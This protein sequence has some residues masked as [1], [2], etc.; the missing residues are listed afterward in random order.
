MKR[1][2]AV[3]AAVVA[4]VPMAPPAAARQSQED[5]ARLEAVEI[6][7]DAVVLDDHRRPVT[8]LT[9]ADFQV[10]EDGKE[11]EIADFTAV[12][13]A[14]RGEAEAAST[15]LPTFR[16]FVLTDGTVQD[17]HFADVVDAVEQFVRERMT[18]SD[19]V[20]L[21][22]IGTGGLAL[23][24]PTTNDREA[25]LKVLAKVT[26]GGTGAIAESIRESARA[27]EQQIPALEAAV[28]GLGA[29][30]AGPGPAVV[31]SRTPG[32]LQ[33]EL[34]FLRTALSRA[35]EI[36]AMRQSTNFYDSLAALIDAH[37]VVPGRRNITMFS[38]GFQTASNTTAFRDTT[39]NAAAAAG[40]ALYVI[41]ARGLAGEVDRGSATRADI[42]RRQSI[43][44]MRGAD[45]N[46][47]RTSS[48]GGGSIFD[49]LKSSPTAVSR[50]DV[51]EDLASGTGGLFLK[52]SNDLAEGLAEIDRDLRNYYVLRYTPRE[53]Q[54]RGEFRRIEVRLRKPGLDV[55]AREGYFAVPA[56]AEGLFRLEDQRLMIRAAQAKPGGGLQFAARPFVSRGAR[57]GTRVSYAIVVAPDAVRL[58]KQEKGAREAR[59]FGLVIA[60]DASGR[61]LATQRLPWTVEVRPEDEERFRDGGLR[62][63]GGLEVTAGE[64]AEVEFVLSDEAANRAGRV[65]AKVRPADWVRG[66]AL[67]DLIIGGVVAKAG[68]R[69]EPAFRSGDL[70]VVPSVVPALARS[71]SLNVVAAAYWPEGRAIQKPVLSIWRG[72]EMVGSVELEI[73]KGENGAGGTVFASVPLKDFAPGDYLARLLVRDAQGRTAK[74][75]ATFTVR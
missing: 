74:R 13:G 54:V 41:D 49:R 40:V 6:V 27:A 37:R 26:S 45:P 68:P 5:P 46:S 31:S 23:V 53:P 16:T 38:E 71:E 14:S 51:L 36:Q 18:T 34:M 50:T 64:V 44:G 67:G 65:E 15:A 10:F 42:E 73:A 32:E 52:N 22:A 20:T 11:Q 39:V 66:P 58:E 21:F 1:V 29:G 56:E 2:A 30:T 57:G 9:K 35:S 61:L 63:D 24:C 62:F 59:L 48:L 12:S 8:G 25:V 72:A 47:E 33:I 7:V 60:R 75:E 69:D 70:V 19:Y 55:R 3:L 17:L 28:A 4:V 43:A